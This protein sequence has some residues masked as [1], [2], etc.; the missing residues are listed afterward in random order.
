VFNREAMTALPLSER[1]AL[2]LVT[3]AAGA[4]A[5]SVRTF[6]RGT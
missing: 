4:R 3:H 6:R 2:P 5:V 1:E